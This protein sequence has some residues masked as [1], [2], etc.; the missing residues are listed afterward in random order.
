MKRAHSVCCISRQ[1]VET[2]DIFATEMEAEKAK[3]KR[4]MTELEW[5]KAE[6]VKCTLS[7]HAFTRCFTVFVLLIVFSGKRMRFQCE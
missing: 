4:M 7:L 6:A 2:F 1:L 3:Y 5:W